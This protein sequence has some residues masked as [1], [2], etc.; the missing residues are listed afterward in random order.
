MPRKKKEVWAPVIGGEAMF[1][2]TSGV[3]G[4]AG[5][6]VRV[7]AEASNKRMIVSAIGLKGET[8]KLTVKSRQLRPAQPDLFDQLA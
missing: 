3:G 4:P 6:R 1:I 5:R 2:S 7:E 8:V